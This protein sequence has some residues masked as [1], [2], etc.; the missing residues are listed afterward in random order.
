MATSPY[1][2][3]VGALA[4]LTLGTRP[5]SAFATSFGHNP[6]HVHWEAAEQ[7]LLYLKGTK[8]QCLKLGGKSPRIV[9]FTDADW[10]SNRDDQRSIGAYMIKIG[11]GAVNWKSK[12]QSCVT[13]PLAEAECMALCLVDFLKNLGTSL[14]GPMVVN[15]DNQGS[16]PLAKNPVFH[17]CSNPAH[18]LCAS[19]SGLGSAASSRAGKD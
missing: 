5:D 14:Q 12:R 6:G 7:V 3:L 17:D 8:I 2:G 13:L 18:H 19:L 4:S 16:I 11:D 9:A 15:V 10:G 1:R